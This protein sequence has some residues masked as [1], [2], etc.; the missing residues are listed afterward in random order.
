M[1]M[2]SSGLEVLIFPDKDNF[3]AW[4]DNSLGNSGGISPFGLYADPQLVL[5]WVWV[6]L[7]GNTNNFTREIF[8]T[9]L[10]W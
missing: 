10:Q 3:G 1:K 5:H 9:K 4:I 6:V 7:F 8:G 2:V